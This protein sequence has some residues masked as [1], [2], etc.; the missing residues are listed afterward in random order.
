MEP[1]LT[2]EELTA[3]RAV[4]NGADVFDYTIA[5]T[6]R[7]VE[8][9]HPRLLDIG[10]SPREYGPRDVHPYFGAILTPAG[11]AVLDPPAP[12]TPNAP[13]RGEE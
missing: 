8:H 5:V 1:D 9:D 10:P 7:R 4:R 3:M 12:E 13:E 2:T 11:V 6:L